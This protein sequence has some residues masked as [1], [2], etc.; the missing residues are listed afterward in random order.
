MVVAAQD[1]KRISVAVWSSSKICNSSGSEMVVNCLS[2]ARF[3][4]H[5]GRKATK[6]SILNAVL[7]LYNKN[8]E[9][10]RPAV[11]R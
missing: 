7:A 11:R 6:E 10:T 9:K 2:V 3:S 5:G 4:K 1:W 8:F